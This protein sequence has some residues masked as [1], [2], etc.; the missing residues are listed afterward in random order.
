[1]TRRSRWLAL[2]AGIGLA[3]AT[4]TSVFGYTTQVPHTITVTPSLG[5]F[6]CGV[7]HIVRATVLD[8][9][10]KPIK[11]L[12]VTWSFASSPSANDKIKKTTSKT[13]THGVAATRVKLACVLGDRV[14][15]ATTDGI[16]GTAVVHVKG[17]EQHVL[18]TTGTPGTPGLPNTSTSPSGTPSDGPL[19]PAIPA[20]LTFV[21]TLAILVRRFAFTRR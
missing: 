18:G 17:D 21:A 6:T 15:M 11:G 7:F 14:I 4:A 9:D 12:T 5:T 10:G 8:Q 3:F 20:V 13:N 19:A 16:S 1:M 2:L